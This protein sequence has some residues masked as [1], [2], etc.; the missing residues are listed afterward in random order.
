MLYCKYYLLNYPPQIEYLD[1]FWFA[2]SNFP[3]SLLIEVLKHRYT[4]LKLSESFDNFK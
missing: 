4:I 2:V 1:E 3:I